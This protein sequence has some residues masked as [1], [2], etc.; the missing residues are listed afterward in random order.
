M[1]HAKIVHLVDFV[2]QVV[3]LTTLSANFLYI[4]QQILCCR[5]NYLQQKMNI[6]LPI[7]SVYKMQ[8]MQSTCH[9]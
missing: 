1:C 6:Y 2:G 5:G 8:E 9:F 7:F 4:G 3:S